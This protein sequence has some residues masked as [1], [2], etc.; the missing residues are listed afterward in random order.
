[1]I[2]IV[3]G[4]LFAPNLIKVR[5]II[6]PC[7]QYSN[8]HSRYAGNNQIN[9]Y[10]EKIST[11]SSSNPKRNINDLEL[12]K[13]SEPVCVSP[14]ESTIQNILNFSKAYEVE[15]TEELGPIGF[16]MN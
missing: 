6:L 11:Y 16:V 1:M 13:N 3:W 14:K 9:P 7:I 15:S 8:S 10:M 2:L 12:L 5:E 4:E